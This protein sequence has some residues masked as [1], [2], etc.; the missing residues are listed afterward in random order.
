VV[1]APLT[2]VSGTVQ[3]VQP[4][5]ELPAP[6]VVRLEDQFGHPLPGQRVTATVIRG[7]G[8][9]RP[10]T[11]QAGGGTVEATSDAQGQASFVLRAGASEGDIQVQV[12]ALDQT[13]RFLAIVGTLDTPDVPRDL[14][15]AGHTVYI[16]DR[17]GGLLVTD[18]SDPA[19]PRPLEPVP[20][21]GTVELLALAGNRLYVAT[22]FP[23]RL[24]ILDATTPSRPVVS[25]SADLPAGVQNHGVTGLAVQ[26]RFAYVVT[27][28]RTA[29]SGTLQ[30]IDIGDPAHPRVVGS[31]S[32]HGQPTDVAVSG[33][34][35][36]VPTRAHGLLVV[37][38]SDPARP[39]LQ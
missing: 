35:A 9:L 4:G 23:P 20:L 16:A 39:A 22:D 34:F 17:F 25:G 28:A 27:D 1:A 38:I 8:A 14:A 37:H 6:L 26:G 7:E 31:L 32:H 11:P 36:Y 21:G 29:P 15:V 13:V 33:S 18:A 3:R 30:V 24:Y 19:N 2:P 10:A 5:Q 12:S